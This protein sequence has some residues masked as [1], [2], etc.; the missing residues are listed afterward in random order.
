MTGR[1]ILA[2]T[3]MA[4]AAT[5]FGAEPEPQD[6]Y[7]SDLSRVYWGYHQV[8]T[9]KEVCDA[10]VPAT[11]AANGAA[12]STWQSQHKALVEELQ[13]RVTAMIRRASTDE[14][15]YTR[16]LGKYEGAILQERQE[17]R[18]SLMKLEAKELRGQCQRMAAVLKSPEADLNQV[19]AVELESIRKRK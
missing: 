7:S 4:A 1:T 2:M 6:S 10:A 18:G 19:Y 15:D 13:R 12:F 5:A 17:Y 14:K 8:L 16:N 11:R 9:Q 3:M